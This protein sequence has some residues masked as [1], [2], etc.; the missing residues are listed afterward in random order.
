MPHNKGDSTHCNL[1]AINNKLLSPRVY[2]YACPSST[3]MALAGFEGFGRIPQFFEK[4]SRIPQY[5]GLYIREYR[6]IYGTK[7][8]FVTLCGNCAILAEKLSIAVE[9]KAPIS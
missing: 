7:L 3:V 4:D 2:F 1:L 9:L 8:G 5:F 6:G